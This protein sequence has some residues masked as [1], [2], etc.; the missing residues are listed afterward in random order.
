MK[1]NLWW[2]LSIVFLL[3]GCDKELM[4]LPVE[5]LKIEYGEK[6][7][8]TKLFYTKDSDENVKVSR[9][10]GF[11]EKKIGKQKLAVT[12]TDGSRKVQKDIEVIVED[13]KKPV[14]ELKKIQ[15][16]LL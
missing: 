8:K 1:G 9:V 5:N 10:D 6:L 7:D 11:D 4:I 3:A 2:R 15:L 13:T 12:F 16:L 14:I